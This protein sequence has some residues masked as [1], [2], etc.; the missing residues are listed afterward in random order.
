MP[1]P[2]DHQTLFD[3]AVTI[4]PAPPTSEDN[5]DEPVVTE[6]ELERYFLSL[7]PL[8]VTI[9]SLDFD[10]GRVEAAP[11]GDIPT[12]PVQ[13]ADLRASLFKMTDSA[14]FSE[15]K[16]SAFWQIALQLGELSII[17]TRDKVT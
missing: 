14:E 10:L 1:Q 6:E 2:S 13:V 15:L 12:D 7:D 9:S 8:P 11:I 3:D 5:A 17:Y 4:P 16:R